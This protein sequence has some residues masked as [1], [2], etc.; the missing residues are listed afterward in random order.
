MAFTKEQVE[1]LKQP[2]NPKN[3]ETRDGNK[4]G[5][6]QLAYVESW[7]VIDE[8]NRIFGFDG[9][10]SET[11]ETTC[12]VCEPTAVT[13]IAKVRVTVGNIIREG[14]GAGHGRQR[15][16][17]GDNHESA[18]KEAES[19][20]RKRALMQFGYQFG[21]SLYD[22]KKGA[23][24]AQKDRSAA[25]AETIFVLALNAIQKAE[26]IE[27][28]MGHGQNVEVRYTQGKL[29]QDEYTELNKQ[30]KIKKE[31]LEVNV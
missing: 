21:L 31:Q 4:S 8:A 9:W 30:I 26:T 19:D 5:T 15:S 28:L 12:V 24:A 16:G 10:S 22:G 17:I 18:I 7:H 1:L 6:F 14:T 23:K 2:I 29:T 11:L 20:A 25:P 13:Y 3:V 27:T